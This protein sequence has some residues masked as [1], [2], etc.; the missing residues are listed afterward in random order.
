M[1]VVS[2]VGDSYR[3]H[4]NEPPYRQ[5]SWWPEGGQSAGPT[6]AEFDALKVKVDEMIAMLKAARQYDAATGAAGCEMDEKLALLRKIAA[7][8]G[9][10]LDSAAGLKSGP[11]PVAA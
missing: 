8:V 6:Q 10:D 9:V 4:F 5:F 7:L 2:F 1:C 3:R 11:S